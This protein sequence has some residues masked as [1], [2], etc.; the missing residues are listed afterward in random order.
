MGSG[1]GH[2]PGNRSSKRAAFVFLVLVLLAATAW[3]LGSNLRSPSSLDSFQEPRPALLTTTVERRHLSGQLIARGTVESV[4]SYRIPFTPVSTEQVSVVTKAG[5][6]K[7]D[8]LSESSLLMEVSGRPVFLLEGT[9]PPYRDLQRGDWGADVQQLNASLTRLGYLSGTE[10]DTYTAETAAALSALYLNAGYSP[11]GVDVRPDEVTEPMARTAFARLGELAYAPFLPAVVS[12][13][14]GVRPGD[15]PSEAA[16]TLAGGGQVVVAEFESSPESAPE[17]GDTA[18]IDSELSNLNVRGVVARVKKIQG[19]TGTTTQVVIRP[20]GS[21]A[22]A[23]L[24][25]DVR[26]RIIVRKEPGRLLTVPL[27]GIWTASDGQSFVTL[28]TDDGDTQDI[29]V[30]TG[31]ETGGYVAVSP[32][33][34]RLHEGDRVVIGYSE[35]SPTASSGE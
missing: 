16:I 31:P 6:A 18:V 33:T 7:G 13:A 4:R 5:V 10:T 25:D 32:R 2:E 14:T 28:V 12:Q 9:I 21:L 23:Q 29:G 24:G 35:S 34:G 17:V 30:T 22:D 19:D 8:V 3:V 1:G 11:P 26:V 20:Q 27:S 15:A